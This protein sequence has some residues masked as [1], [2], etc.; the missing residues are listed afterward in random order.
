MVEDFQ[1]LWNS[2]HYQKLREKNKDPNKMVTNCMIWEQRKVLFIHIPKTAGFSIKHVLTHPQSLTIPETI[3][4]ITAK[5]AWPLIEKYNF[6]DYF[7]TAF[8]RNP[9]D[10]FVSMYFYF[11]NMTPDHYAYKYDKDIAKRVQR[12]K[13]FEEF[14]YCFYDVKNKIGKLPFHMLNQSKWTH[15]KGTCFVDYIGRFENLKEDFKKLEKIMRLPH[16]TIKHLN[17]SGHKD[18]KTYYNSETIDIVSRLYKED[19][20]N[21]NYSYET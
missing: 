16:R 21:F 18:Y 20:I 4:P 11:K 15:H 12:I 14:C 1:K 6:K 5:G 2:P 10:R 13:T 17:K 19:I 7:K 3:H 9:W 8:V